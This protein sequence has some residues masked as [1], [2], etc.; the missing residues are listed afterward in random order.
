M[1]KRIEQ[2][3]KIFHSTK[4]LLCIFGTRLLYIIMKLQSHQCPL[5][6][7]FTISSLNLEM[8]RL[9]VKILVTKLK[10]IR[11]VW[12]FVNQKSKMLFWFK[13]IIH[14]HE[15]TDSSVSSGA[16]FHDYILKSGNENTVC[17][18]LVLKIKLIGKGIYR[19]LLIRR[20][21]CVLGTKLL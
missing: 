8:R 18:I 9:Y 13:I 21:L 15:A 7:V 16:C 11:K 10:H 14:P 3:L 12:I 4:R 17:K 20:L 2:S 1:I 5:G 6:L 19:F